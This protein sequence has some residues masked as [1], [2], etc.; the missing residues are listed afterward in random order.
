MTKCSF[1]PQNP[2]TTCTITHLLK[3]LRVSMISL[4][5]KKFSIRQEKHTL[6]PRAT[7]PALRFAGGAGAGGPPCRNQQ[8]W[9]TG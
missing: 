9:V 7:G 3:I 2:Q 5:A 8:P 6:R 4:K 1:K